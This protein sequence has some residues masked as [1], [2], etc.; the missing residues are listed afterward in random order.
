MDTNFENMVEGSSV[1]ENAIVESDQAQGRFSL[2]NFS[3]DASMLGIEDITMPMLRLAQGLTTEV[4]NGEAKPGQW[5][6]TGYSPS[7]TLTIVPLMFARHRTLR[8]AEGGAVLCHASDALKGSGMPGGDCLKCPKASWVDDGKGHRFPP[9]CVFSYMYTV[10]V[11]EHKT[12]AMIDFRRT[13]IN[14]GKQLNLMVIRNGCG[15][16]A[17]ALSSTKESG[18][19]GTFY[20]MRIAPATSVSP[21]AL[22]EAKQA[23]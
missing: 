22:L 17:V 4:Q 2:S 13:N 11:I 19:R 23:L 9:E 15:N 3:T 16:F 10:Y 7:D 5:L 6:L 18:K 1:E 12:I 8:A 20:G 21:Q 14:A